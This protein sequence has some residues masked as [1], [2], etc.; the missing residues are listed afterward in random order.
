[1]GIVAK[2]SD[3]KGG[4]REET[5]VQTRIQKIFCRTSYSVKEHWNPKTQLA[6]KQASKVF[7]SGPGQSLKGKKISDSSRI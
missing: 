1:M 3:K 5:G 4:C 2:W 7:T 6:K